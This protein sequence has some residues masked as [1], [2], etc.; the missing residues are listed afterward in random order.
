MIFKKLW[1]LWVDLF[2]EESLE[3]PRFDPLHLAIVLV[4][5]LATVGVLFWLLW[6]ALVYEGGLGT[7]EGWIANAVALMILVAIIEA[8]RRADRRHANRP[9]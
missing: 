5:C 7:G 4:A 6:T 9:K 3:T 8:L 2:Q 1:E